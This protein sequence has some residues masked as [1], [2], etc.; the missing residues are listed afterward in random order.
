MSTYGDD[1][2]KKFD[3][4]TSAE[5]S[6]IWRDRDLNGYTQE[7]LDVAHDILVLRGLIMEEAFNTVSVNSQEE[8]GGFFSFRKMITPTL[9]KIIYVLG[10]IGVVIYG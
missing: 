9:I 4:M 8:K 1:I 5:L 7:A 2:R 10:I 3:E 6:K